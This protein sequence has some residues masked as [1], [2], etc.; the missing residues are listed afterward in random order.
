METCLADADTVICH[1]LNH[2]R[3]SQDLATFFHGK[4]LILMGGH[5][6]EREVGH[7][8]KALLA[9]PRD[10]SSA[11]FTLQ[12]NQVQCANHRT[13][14]QLV[15]CLLTK[16]LD[17]RS[18]SDD[19]IDHNRPYPGTNPGSKPGSTSGAS[20]GPSVGPSPRSSPRMQDESSIE[21]RI[22]ALAINTTSQFNLRTVR[23]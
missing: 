15:A 14:L 18:I 17:E 21:N 23:C 8:S 3:A 13:Q 6:S 11:P 5:I 22:D 4:K 2:P 20:P 12:L 10:V 7:L 19:V 16:E 1:D 9:R